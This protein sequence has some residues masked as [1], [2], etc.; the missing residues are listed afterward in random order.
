[1]THVRKLT[2]D[3][4]FAST[5]ILGVGDARII[6]IGEV[7][8]LTFTDESFVIGSNRTFDRIKE[9]IENHNFNEET[10]CFDQK[11]YYLDRNTGL[12]MRFDDSEEDKST[13]L[14]FNA[15]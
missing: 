1:M 7:T 13:S 12:I 2:D 6:V 10:N 3:G 5:D 14:I 4:I 9:N 11:L 8:V 15:L